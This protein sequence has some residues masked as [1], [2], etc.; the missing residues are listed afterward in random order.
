MFSVTYV[1]E[2]FEEVTILFSDIV[3]FTNIAAAVT[4]IEVV[5]MLNQLYRRFD[6]LSTENG[7]YK[8]ISIGPTQIQTAGADLGIIRG[9]GGF[10]AGIHQGG[11]GNFHI[12]TTTTKRPGGG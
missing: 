11:G 8:V 6:S 3:T 5:H 9:G 7:V 1:S 12:L 2:K 4:P 10:W